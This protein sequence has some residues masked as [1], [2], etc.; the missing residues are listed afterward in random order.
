MCREEKK[1]KNLLWSKKEKRNG[2]ETIQIKL[3]IE[4]W[5]RKC[6]GKRELEKEKKWRRSN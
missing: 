3:G 1:F 2:K 5:R 4:K 6:Q